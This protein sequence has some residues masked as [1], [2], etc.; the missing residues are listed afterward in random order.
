MMASLNGIEIEAPLIPN[1][2]IPRTAPSRSSVVKALYKKFR[3]S[4]SYKKLWNL[5][6]RFVGF[7]A[8]EIHTCMSLL[9]I[10]TLQVWQSNRLMRDLSNA[11]LGDS[12]GR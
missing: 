10:G 12:I 8:S 3:F 11:Q 9:S 5:V 7:A 6:P 1:A 2:L 4:S